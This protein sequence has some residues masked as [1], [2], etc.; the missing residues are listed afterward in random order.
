MKRRVDCRT[1]AVLSSSPGAR[2]TAL[3][4]V[5]SREQLNLDAT[6]DCTLFH[7]FTSLGLKGASVCL[8]ELNPKSSEPSRESKGCLNVLWLRAQ[9][10]N[11]C[12]Q[13]K[14]L[15]S[16][17]RLEI[18][19]LPDVPL[20]YWGSAAYLSQINFGLQLFLKSLT[21]QWKHTHVHTYTICCCRSIY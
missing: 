5:S 9:F 10:Q 6:A 2:R 7:Q 18:C 21:P 11:R 1:S 13:K 12:R 15:R 17:V 3:C 14:K 16:A 8:W 4:A 20:G 19:M